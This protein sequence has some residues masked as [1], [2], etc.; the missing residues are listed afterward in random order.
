[1]RPAQQEQ[2]DLAPMLLEGDRTGHGARRQRWRQLLHFRK[3]GFELLEIG[4]QAGFLL[5]I[6]SPYDLRL[7]LGDLGR[8]G[9]KLRVNVGHA[10]H[11][12]ARRKHVL[13]GACRANNL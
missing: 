13:P 9:S 12:H 11:T 3:V 2:L 4:L 7:E 1:M 6:G 8:E 10:T 5:S